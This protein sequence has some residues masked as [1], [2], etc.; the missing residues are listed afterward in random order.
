MSTQQNASVKK[1]R[2]KMDAEGCARLEITIGRIAIDQARELAK[3]KQC[4][5]WQ[6][7]QE[8]LMAY[9]KAVNAATSNAAV[10][11]NGK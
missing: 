11:G 9:V 6:V 4:P 5:L 1:H 2:A 3:R 8:A 7:V 10:T